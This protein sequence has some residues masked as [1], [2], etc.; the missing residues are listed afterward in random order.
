MSSQRS[1]ERPTWKK[2]FFR[3]FKWVMGIVLTLLLVAFILL[4]GAATPILNAYL[5]DVE[6]AISSDLGR[7]LKISRVEARVFPSLRFKLEGLSLDDLVQVDAVHLEFDTLSALLSG[8]NRLELDQATVNGAHLTLIKG[9][10]QRWN[11]DRPQQDQGLKDQAEGQEEAEIESEL[12]P[13]SRLTNSDNDQAPHSSNPEAL[14]RL[15]RALNIGTLHMRG[16]TVDLIDQSSAETPKTVTLADLDLDF[17]IL[18]PAEHIKFELK[19]NLLG[20]SEPVEFKFDVGPYDNYLDPKKG[21]QEKPSLREQLDPPFP[22]SISARAKSLKLELLDPLIEGQGSSLSKVT[23]GGEIGI[24]FRP[25]EAISVKGQWAINGFQPNKNEKLVLNL[26]ILPN[27]KLSLRDEGMLLDLGGTSIQLNDMTLSLNGN[28]ERN[29]SHVKFDQLKIHNPALYLETLTALVP[30]LRTSLPKGTELRGPLSF[31]VTSKGD[32][33]AQSLHLKLG[34]AETSLLIPELFTKEAKENLALKADLKVSPQR[35]LLDL[36]SLQLG[37]TVFKTEGEIGLGGQSPKVTLEFT[38]LEAT[39]SELAR[40]IPSVKKSLASQASPVAG[41]L[42]LEGHLKTDPRGE[43][44]YIDA[45]A[46]FMV[47]GA[48][49]DTPAVK[50]IGN[51]GAITRFKTSG[52]SGFEALFDSNLSSLDLKFGEAFVKSRGTAFDIELEA[53]SD[54]KQFDI[55]QL[56][57][58]LAELKLRGQGRRD[59]SGFHMQADLPSTQLKSVLKMFG[60]AS[61]LGPDL[62]DGKLSLKLSIDAGVNP[63]SDLTVK[64]SDLSLKSRG[65]DLRA[66]LSLTDLSSPQVNFSMSAS[67]IDL[68][69][70]LP[71]E[72]AS[73]QSKSKGSTPPKKITSTESSTAH[74]QERVSFNFGGEVKIK[75]GQARG[76]KFKDLLVNLNASDREIHLKTL[77]V[78]AF[79]GE[80]E[81]HPFKA[82]LSPKGQLTDWSSRLM[83]KAIDL[84]SV[85]S[86]MTV[87]HSLSGSLSGGFDLKAPGISVDEL[88]ESLSGAGEFS[89]KDGV[90]KGLNIQNLL[91]KS[92]LDALPASIKKAG[93]VPSASSLKLGASDLKLKPIKGS[94]QIKGGKLRFN[95]WQETKISN[96]VLKFKGEV[97]LNGDL[98]VQ[99]KLILSA[100]TA[101]DWLKTKI[102]TPS[103]F[104]LDFGL[105]GNLRKPS[106]EGFAAAGLLGAAALAYGVSKLSPESLGGLVDE[107]A[108]KAKAIGEQAVKDAK[109]MAGEVTEQLKSKG[110]SAKKRAKAEAEKAAKKAEEQ[111]GIDPETAKKAKGKTK[112]EAE[113]KAKEAKKVLKGLF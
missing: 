21:T 9:Q 70:L 43:S 81:A 103:S 83:L 16:L 57:L 48:H 107:G 33:R 67:K 24:D 58:Q 38:L 97:G 53:K 31:E 77:S 34:L 45:E 91:I 92:T 13:S 99:S 69:R 47:S 61:T 42:N 71:P 76:V 37:R 50:M 27:L 82:Q 23:S 85:Q 105:G 75:Q 79:K 100:A 62:H 63:S 80:I 84:Q 17:P 98:K 46:R 29:E 51:G 78:K 10:D 12:N 3:L 110:E 64:L 39:V 106:I 112:R 22:I 104:P 19:G 90:I 111:L 94:V 18:K 14:A 32:E 113:R 74:P 52:K 54:G 108:K 96:D 102:T 60:A 1:S 30:S 40:F 55:P 25:S 59:D 101:S 89:L 36:F 86:A 49:L 73:A 6:S 20:S 44:P 28:V 87:K 35:L 93:L 72:P 2:I 95:E 68:D 7:E 56:N 5:K 26:S 4:S 11:F 66:S 88:T 109:K 15:L 65:T 41:Q 8:G